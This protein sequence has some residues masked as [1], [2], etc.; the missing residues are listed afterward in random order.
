M[1]KFLLQGV[2]LLAGLL[3]LLGAR[4]AHAIPQAPVRVAVFDDPAYV[5]T[6]TVAPNAESDNVQASLAA[7]GA[8]VSTFTG[9]TEASWRAAAA[10]A[11]VVLVPELENADLAAA[12]D[13]SAEQALV[14]FVGAGGTLI[15]HGN[16]PRGVGLINAVFGFAISSQS[17]AAS[18]LNANF[19]SGTR[20]AFGPAALPLPNGATS[21]GGMTGMYLTAAVTAMVGR[22][23]VGAGEVI[24]LGWDWFDAAPL[25]SQDGGWNE[26]LRRAILEGRTPQ[27]R[28]AVYADPAFTDTVSPDPQAEAQNVQASLVKLDMLATRVT[29]SSDGAFQAA[30][31]AARRPSVDALVVPEL[32]ADLGATLVDAAATRL[33]NF[34]GTGGTLVVLGGLGS[35]TNPSAF[36]NRVFGF[37]TTA[38]SPGTTTS[39]RTSDVAGTLYGSGTAVLAH[40]GANGGLG[41]LPPGSRSV[42]VSG[43]AT[44]VALIPYGEGSIHFIGWSWLNAQPIGANDGGW[45][46]LLARAVRHSAPPRRVALFANDAYVDAIES[47]PLSAVGAE[48]VGMAASLVSRG[49]PVTPFTATDRAGWSRALSNADVLAIPDL[50]NA[51]L[52]NVLDAATREDVGRFVRNGGLL[53]LCANGTGRAASLAN[54]V[55]DLGL[56]E[57]GGGGVASAMT[58][59]TPGTP[60]SSGPAN[61]PA[62]NATSFVSGPSLLPIYAAGGSTTVGWVS[63][64]AGHVLVLGWDFY[65]AAPAGGPQDGGWVDVLDLAVQSVRPRT[66][67]VAVFADDDYVNT[68]SPVPSPEA[69]TVPAALELFDHRVSELSG[70]SAATFRAA[71]AGVDT[72]LIPNQ[73]VASLA[74]ALSSEAR[75]IV[76]EFVKAG[77]E[78]IVNADTASRSPELLNAIFGWSTAQ[79]PATGSLFGGAGFG[80]RFAGGAGLLAPIASARELVT[81]SLPPGAQSIY[82]DDS[83]NAAVVELPYGRGRVIYLGWTFAGTPSLGALNLPWLDVLDRAAQETRLR[84]RRI[85]IYSDSGYVDSTPGGE[86]RN[87]DRSLEVLG[88]A[89]RTYFFEVY[90]SEWSNALARSQALFLPELEVGSLAADIPV[91]S[92]T[93]QFV[94]D[95]VARGGT[96]VAA[97]TFNANTLDFLNRVFGFSLASQNVSIGEPFALAPAA[98]GGVFATGPARLPEM[99]A[100]YGIG[101]LPPGSVAP[102][103]NSGGNAVVQI[104]YGAGHVVVLAWDFFGAR[105]YDVSDVGQAAW[106]EVLRRALELA[107]PDARH[108]ALFDNP[109][110]S[111]AAPDDPP[112]FLAATLLKQEHAVVPFSGTNLASFQ[113]ALSRADT[114]I[115]PDQDVPGGILVN[116]L[117]GATEDEIRRFVRG[118]GALVTQEFG[119]A[120]LANALF[121]HVISEFSE[122]GVAP[123]PLTVEAL[124][125]RFSGGPSA[126]GAAGPGEFTGAWYDLPVGGRR[127]YFATFARVVWLAEGDGRVAFLGFDYVNAAPLGTL[128]SGW[129]ELLDRAV[130]EGMGNDADG[131]GVPPGAELCPLTS[132]PLQGDGDADGVGDACDSCVS[133]ANPR[134]AQ[135]DDP[136]LAANVWAT[137]TGA[138]RDDDHDGFGNRCDAKFPTTPGIVVTSADLAQFR[139]ANGKLRSVD[140]CG[141]AGI[142]PCAIY[143]LDEAGVVVGSGDLGVFRARLGKLPGPRCTTCPLPCVAGASGSCEELPHP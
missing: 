143:D 42:Y 17:A 2:A 101:N 62:S 4:A 7:L 13:E 39:T 96:L 134:V 11:D 98:V 31:G 116:T 76:R 93:P 83:N 27:R 114:L 78:L 117:D 32:T 136:F 14:D 65:D 19:S 90:E 115:V 64:G 29:A 84:A 30:L 22:V 75:G 71:L 24:F 127:I 20:F 97:Q 88:H 125:T 41:G 28:V 79:Q 47:P 89:P 118:G 119:S 36:L 45:L 69:E 66:R 68:V 82:A 92:R 10:S 40:F 141:T 25:G 113:A 21:A 86:L 57:P 58:A 105:P 107:P 81:S 37:S 70:T 129:L 77:G 59:E 8:A 26:V 67:H 33:R 130:R 108:V 95:F 128:D 43:G 1:A 80:T 50:E 133:I 56:S 48:G 38:Q 104:P 122:S 123:N 55:L 5:D 121:G 15:V 35:N 9:V 73:T 49:H 53:V 46:D 135:G 12:M 91:G 74:P 6:T 63:A 23:P 100:V 109:A 142:F 112:R 102:Y 51:S 126:V 34:V 54:A 3:L 18:S 132:D 16:T 61:L 131:D 139:S 44:T 137:L 106:R 94:R 52:H 111:G 87:A 110:F 103:A 140:T 124:G 85:A 99:N 72:L 138:Q 120:S 60:F